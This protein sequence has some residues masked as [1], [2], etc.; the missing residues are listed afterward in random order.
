MAK[1]PSLTGYVARFIVETKAAR[2]PKDVMH[3]GKRSI[4]DGLGLALAGNAAE[5]GHLVRRPD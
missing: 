4:L 3:L 5:S 1:D 2:I